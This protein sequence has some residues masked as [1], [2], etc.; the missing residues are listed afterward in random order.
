V[1]R[2][3]TCRRHKP[4]EEFNSQQKKCRSCKAAYDRRWY[5]K[6]KTRRDRQITLRRAADKER[7]ALF[8]L[9]YLLDHPCAV[10]GETD[11]VVLE[12]DHI[13]G[14]KLYSISLIA[15]NGYSMRVLEAEIAKC[16]VLCANCHRRRTAKG[17]HLRSKRLRSLA[18]LRALRDSNS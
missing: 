1:K 2:C 12:F 14:K 15:S 16:Q 18:T 11:T 5:K 8:V 4:L 3:P 10:C 17:W 9:N 6:N 7:N 13:R